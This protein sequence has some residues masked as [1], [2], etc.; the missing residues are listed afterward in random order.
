[1]PKDI[2]NINAFKKNKKY[3]NLILQIR[4]LFSIFNEVSKFIGDSDKTIAGAIKTDPYNI[5][6]VVHVLKM[7][8]YQQKNIVKAEQK[9]PDIIIEEAIGNVL[10]ECVNP[11][12]WNDGN[13][14]EKGF[15]FTLHPEEK[16]Y[17]YSSCVKDKIEKFLKWKDE[18][19]IKLTDIC[20]IAVSGA[21][22]SFSES[23]LDI[24]DIMKTVYPYGTCLSEIN[25]DNPSELIL[26]YNKVDKVINDR[27]T[28]LMTDYFC[29]N[30]FSFISGILFYPL[31]LTNDRNY[32]GNGFVFVHNKNASNPLP[33]NYLRN[34]KEY[35]GSC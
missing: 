32:D 12:D 8:L 16:I 31:F 15:S 19:L 30:E 28:E 11:A 1:M 23:F 7:L 21:K 26:K 13:E 17:R 25:S 22:Q 24:P 18:G 2:K 14:A 34:V 35:V 33:P 4:T 5:L 6:W 10:I 9:G 3:K 27:N 29:R 20:I